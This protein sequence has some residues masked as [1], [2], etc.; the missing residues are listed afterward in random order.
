MIG[1]WD[2]NVVVGKLPQKVATAFA[3]LGE[4]IIGATYTPI[5]Y[6]GSQIVNGTNHAVL[7]E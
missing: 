1:N 5:A 2:I 7:A 4:T 3:N 6:I